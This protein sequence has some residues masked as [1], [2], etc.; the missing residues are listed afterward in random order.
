MP[1]TVSTPRRSSDLTRACAPVTCSG[2]GVG[3]WDAERGC[4][5]AAAAGGPLGAWGTGRGA[6]LGAGATVAVGAA[7]RGRGWACWATSAGVGRT[8][9]A[10]LLT[11]PL[12]SLGG[13][14]S[15]ARRAFAAHEKSLRSAKDRRAAR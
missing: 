6:L 10:P 8:G 2:A 7:E 12:L 4:A 3:G 5:A 13:R 9:V 1:K 15:C 11:D 14:W